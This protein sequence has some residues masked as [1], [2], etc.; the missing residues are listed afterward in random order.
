MFPLQAVYMHDWVSRRKF[1]KGVHKISI[2]SQCQ[3]QFIPP[4]D[5]PWSAQ[6]WLAHNSHNITP[7]LIFT[8]A[9]AKHHWSKYF[10][11]VCGPYWYYIQ[12]HYSR[13]LYP[14]GDEKQNEIWHHPIAGGCVIIPDELL[15]STGPKPLSPKTQN[16]ITQTKGPW[17][18]TKI[19]WAG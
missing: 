14:L 17:A 9:A 19:S 1:V 16:P 5:S 4:S 8:S 13:L 15:S 11:R 3:E 10:E 18:D 7:S 12:S 2:S 6:L